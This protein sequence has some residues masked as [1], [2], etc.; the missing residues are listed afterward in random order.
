[1]KHK[2]KISY[3]AYSFRLHEGT[4]EMMKKFK[5]KEGK[6]W[7]RILYRLLHEQEEKERV[8]R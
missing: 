3:K 5:E 6:S 1:M 4:Y 8:S 2:E 7:N